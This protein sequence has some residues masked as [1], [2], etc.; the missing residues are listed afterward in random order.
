MH[1]EI[2]VIEKNDTWELA[3]LPQA[4]IKD[5]IGVKWL[6]KTKSNAKGRIEKHKGCLLRDTNNIP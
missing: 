4:R 2:V 1:E 6:Y 5:G 3:G